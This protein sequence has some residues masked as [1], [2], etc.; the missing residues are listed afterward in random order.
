MKIKFITPEL[1]TE[2]AALAAAHPDLVFQNVGYEYIGKTKREAHATQIA[3]I[4]EILKEHITGFVK[5]FNFRRDG[6]NLVLR[7]DYNWGAADN[8]RYFVG[9]G[10]LPLDHLLNGFPEGA[11][12]P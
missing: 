1:Y 7:F 6:G 10:Y 12:L 5:F 2:L 8:T 9:V 11:T 3:R 4:E